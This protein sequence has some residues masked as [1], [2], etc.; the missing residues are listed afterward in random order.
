MER[1]A[2]V[3]RR[4]TEEEVA[5]AE[6]RAQV[7]L[8]MARQA[9]SEKEAKAAEV[10][11]L[12]QELRGMERR[13]DELRRQ[14]REQE[15]LLESR[16]DT[17]KA[18]E[19]DQDR[20]QKDTTTIRKEEEELRHQSQLLRASLGGLS[21]ENEELKRRLAAL[22]EEESSLKDSEM[23]MR[24]A[25][26]HSR[27]GVEEAQIELGEVRSASERERRALADLRTKRSVA[28]AE[29]S[30]Q[31]EALKFEA[32]RV[33]QEALHRAEVEAA[34]ARSHEEMT[35]SQ[36]ALALVEKRL[37]DAVRRE[38]ELKRS[39]TA[40]K[41]TM[42]KL[43]LEIE[44]LSCQQTNE[45][46]TVGTAR[47]ELREINLDI[48]RGKESL[49]VVQQEVQTAQLG[50][51]T[52]QAQRNHL[53]SLKD[54][55]TAELNRIRE[56]ARQ[57]MHRVDKLDSL[58]TDAEQRLKAVR[59]DLA[60][61]EQAHEQTRSLGV[62]EEQR[63]QEQRRALRQVMDELGK[64]E[65][66]ISEGHQQVYEERQ[67]ALVEIGQLSQAKQSAQ[68]HMFLTAEA[69]RRL[70][71]RAALPSYG[72]SLAAGRARDASPQRLD[73]VLNIPD[74]LHSANTS[75][76]YRA[77]PA[78]ATS[79]VKL[80]AGATS[81]AA[82]RLSA[83]GAGSGGLSRP[84]RDAR[85]D[86]LAPPTVVRS[87]PQDSLAGPAPTSAP[88]HAYEPQLR[89]RPVTQTPAGREF[90]LTFL[91]NE[92][93]NLKLRSEAAMRNASLPG[94]TGLRS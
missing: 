59:A 7:A 62:E 80:S 50:L 52:L 93:E 89:A 28:E 49:R 63:V 37:E 48:R 11:A 68:A 91:Q 23:R 75:T 15:M 22:K 90:S 88:P 45:K 65:R 56:S 76:L 41:S 29:M 20:R 94:T 70:D 86:L 36:K 32:E 34:T 12:A 13:L 57:E 84:L 33:Q 6:H 55:L 21:R 51:E 81:A 47:E 2:E 66:K 44:S 60:A 3:R 25:L 73:S 35:R 71:S 5:R 4:T 27:K 30:R 17:V 72:A 82:E 92:V 19:G 31:E 8:R 14:A 38:D 78:L 67:R 69:Q 85:A 83:L 39:E 79:G 10:G 87:A 74:Y 9:E 43:R 42:E 58:Y 64:V 40:L 18:L 16:R 24:T 61:A 53:E 54:E 1:A 77:T 26:Q 46:S